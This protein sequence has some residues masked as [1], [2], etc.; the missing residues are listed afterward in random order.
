ML[1]PH[2]AELLLSQALDAVADGDG[3]R[4]VLDALPVPVYTTDADGAV[5]Y[6]NQAC[7]A[8]AGR[9]PRL[10]HDRWCV[11]WR[12]YTMDGDPLPHDRCPMAEAIRRGESIRDEIAIAERPTGNRVAFRPYPTPLRGADGQVTGAINML[13]DITEQQC[14]ALADQA[15]RCRRLAE[16]TT[17]PRAAG[18]LA[19]M[20]KAY[21]KNAKA[22]RAS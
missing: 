5:T 14:G 22:L 16:S 13:I 9:E 18:I 21:E 2:Q 17:D 19:D 6:W 12:L 4:A 3:A 15:T 1:A 8:F 7:V 11:T 20:A 10:G